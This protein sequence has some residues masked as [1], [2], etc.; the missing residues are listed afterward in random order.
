HQAYR[1]HLQAVTRSCRWTPR[2]RRRGPRTT[3]RR[4]LPVHAA[5]RPP[6]GRAPR[7]PRS[8]IASPL[9]HELHARHVRIPR[10]PSAE[11][12]EHRATEEREIE[13]DAPVVDVPDIERQSIAPRKRVAAVHLYE[14][15][16]A[17]THLV[18]A[19]LL[20]RVARQVL[21]Q[22]R[23]RTDERHLAP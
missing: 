12:G 6:P 16:D 14:A 22:Q 9:A 3:V 19:P 8:G 23:A 7:H 4:A 13:P 21:R 15:G 11:Y 18:P 2:R 17:G 10:A 1:R 20:R 5:T